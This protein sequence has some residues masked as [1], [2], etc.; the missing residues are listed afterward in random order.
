[1]NSNGGFLLLAK[2]ADDLAPEA[3][4]IHKV[5]K[6]AEPL[7]RLGGNEYEKGSHYVA[8]INNKPHH[9]VL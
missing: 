2:S 5:R 1:M 4:P 9:F 7:P 6:A 8:S 3:W